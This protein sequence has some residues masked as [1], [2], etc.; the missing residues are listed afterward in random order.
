MPEPAPGAQCEVQ[1]PGSNSAVQRLIR[2]CVRW[3][4]LRSL[5][6]LE[7]IPLGE[8]ALRIWRS[9]WNDD[10]F[11]SA[12]Q[13]GYWFLFALFPTL[14]SASSLLGL[15]MHHGQQ[16]YD[17]LLRFAAFFLPPSAYGFVYQTFNE[18]IAGSNGRKLTFGLIV[19]LWAASAGFSAMQDAMNAVYKIKESRPYWKARGAAFLIGTLLSLMLTAMLGILLATD[20]CARLVWLHI[21]HR[22]LAGPIAIIVRIVGWFLATAMLSLIFAVIYYW[23]PDLK[24]RHWRWLTPGAAVGMAGWLV[25]SAGLR[26]YLHFFNTYT[27]TY[28]SLG[29]VIVMLTWFYLSGLMLLLGGEVNSEIEAASTERR[30]HMQDVIVP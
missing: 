20:F 4:P 13:M 24:Q 15:V 5:W 2:E 22:H 8:L 28:G 30:L 11:A 23:A 29:A 14:V 26:L 10:L 7:G 17:R 25:A 19:A 27:A 3:R 12:A 1:P 18:I 16:N 21:W 6:N 9:T